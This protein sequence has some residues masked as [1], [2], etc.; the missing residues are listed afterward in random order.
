MN[1][2]L[3]TMTPEE[4]RDAMWTIDVFERWN[5]SQGEVDE[6]RRRISA[7][8]RFLEVDATETAN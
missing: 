3:S 5:M 4:V 1:A 8:R 6:W 2:I 7:R